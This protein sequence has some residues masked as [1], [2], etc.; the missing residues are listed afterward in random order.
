[1]RAGAIAR[2]Y[3]RALFA[4]A[5]QQNELEQVG[6]ALASISEVVAEPTVM[7]ILTGPLTRARKRDLVRKVVDAAHAPTVL[8][9]FLLLLVDHDRLKQLVA[10]RAVF[11]TL[12]DEKHGIT[13]AKIRTAVPLSPDMLDETTRVFGTLTGKKVVAQIEVVPDLIAGLIVEIDGRVYDGSLRTELA[14][15]RQQMATGS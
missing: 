15:L 3:A 10:M 5:A 7:R 6:S 1:M 2:R 12:L 4:L 14:K 8:R 9:D 11:E 13:R